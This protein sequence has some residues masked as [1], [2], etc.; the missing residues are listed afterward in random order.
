MYIS[1]NLVPLLCLCLCGCPHIAHS[2]SVFIV[3]WS[4]WD[5]S[6]ASVFPSVLHS[7]PALWGFN[8]TYQL[9]DRFHRCSSGEASHPGP[10]SLTTEGVPSVPGPLNQDPRSG[11]LSPSAPPASQVLVPPVAPAPHPYVGVPGS[12]PA[13]PPRPDRFCFPA[14]PR[15]SSRRLSGSP[16]LHRRPV[17]AHVCDAPP[18]DQPSGPATPRLFCPVQ[19]CPDHAHPLMGGC[20]F[21]PCGPTLRRICRVSSWA[22]FRLAGSTAKVSAHVRFAR[23]FSA[24][25][26]TAGVPRVSIPW[27]LLTAVPRAAPA[28]L[29]RGH[30]ASGMFSPMVHV[31]GH[32]SRLVH[33]TLSLDASL[34]LLLVRPF[35]ESLARLLLNS[36]QTGHAQSLCLFS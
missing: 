29:P 31:L 36:S 16:A 30:P 35:A 22:I 7:G 12:L 24:C 5:S 20:L 33:A 2:G 21:T 11:A 23:G 28:L 19:S 18:L 17:N 1:R 10:T 13:L 14:L 32:R 34:L 9:A 4:L 25:G 27:L 3:S 8:G 15:S 6:L 26:S